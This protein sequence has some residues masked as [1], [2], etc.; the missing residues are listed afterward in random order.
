MTTTTDARACEPSKIIYSRMREQNKERINQQR[1]SENVSFRPDYMMNYIVVKT[2]K[3]VQ[4]AMIRK[5]RN[6]KENPSPI[7][8]VGKTK[9]TY[10]MKK[11]RK[12][13]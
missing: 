6:Q 2:S 3:K 5:R 8:K 13:N 4:V 1:T 12:P 9:L 10:T 11:Y 7:T